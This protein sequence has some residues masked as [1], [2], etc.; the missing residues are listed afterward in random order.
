MLVPL[1]HPPEEIRREELLAALT[2][3]PLPCLRAVAEAHRRPGDLGR[4][5]EHLDH[6]DLSGALALVEQLVGPG[7]SLPDGALRDELEAAAQGRVTHG[8]FRAGLAEPGG[9]SRSGW[10]THPRPTGTPVVP[11]PLPDRLR[12]DHRRSREHPFRPRHANGFP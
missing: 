9:G 4:I 11:G 1:D 7:A 6:G 5:R 8:L 12:P 2:G 3:T 10:R